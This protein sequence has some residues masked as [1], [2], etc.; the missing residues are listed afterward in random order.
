L[1]VLASWASL[2]AIPLLLFLLV[3]ARR[4]GVARVHRGQRLLVD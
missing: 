3:R 2:L 4:P 1:R